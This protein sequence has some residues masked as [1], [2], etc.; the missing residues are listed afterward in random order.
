MDE[1]TETHSN[2]DILSICL[3]FVSWNTSTEKIS[4]QPLM[5]EVFFDFIYLTRTMGLFIA[6]AIK[7]S[8]VTHNVDISKARGQAYD[9][10]TAMS[11][12][13]SGVQMCIHESAP[14]AVK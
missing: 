4:P 10:A 5:K 1:V 8:L 6:N 3:C 9:D 11:S 13:I 7:V 12:N 2:K 14:L